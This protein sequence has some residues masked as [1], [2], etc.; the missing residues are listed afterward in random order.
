MRAEVS[1]KYKKN[2]ESSTHHFLSLI[3][4]NQ[5]VMVL[6]KPSDAYLKLLRRN[7][8]DNEFGEKFGRSSEK[9]QII[10]ITF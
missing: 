2:A 3:S 10:E 8:S 7:E 9:L 4:Q 1:R 6:C 5:G